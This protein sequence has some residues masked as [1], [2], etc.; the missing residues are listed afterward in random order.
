[1]AREIFFWQDKIFF[2][3]GWFGYCDGKGNYSVISRE[4][5][6][7]MVSD[8]HA[9]QASQDV[10]RGG[11]EM[12]R[13]FNGRGFELVDGKY[14]YKGN[15]VERLTDG[16]VREIG[17]ILEIPEKVGNY[18]IN[19][20]HKQAFMG[21]KQIKKVILHEKIDHIG[22]KAFADC[23][24]LWAVQG[25]SEKITVMADAFANTRLFAGECAEYLKNVLL[26]VNT[27][28]QGLFVVKSGITSIAEKAFM[29]CKEITE[30]DLPESVEYIENFAFQDCE[31]LEKIHMPKSL[32]RLGAGAFAGCKS[33]KS[34]IVP[35]GVPE[36]HRGTF[37]G[38]ESL[39]EVRLPETIVSIGHDAFQETALM[40]QFE[41]GTEEALYVD[42]W[43]IRYKEDFAETL[44]I[45]K[46][47]VGVADMPNFRKRYL[48]SVAFPEGLKYIG[49]CA[50]EKTDLKTLKLPGTLELLKRSA[51][52][53][54]KIK[55]VTLPESVKQVDEW[56]FMDCEDIE[57]I[58]V[59]GKDTQI[60][61][62]AVTDRTGGLTTVIEAPLGSHAQAYCEQ[63]GKKYNLVFEE[64][65]PVVKNNIFT[66]RRKK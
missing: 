39:L 54:T 26:K 23:E 59:E 52:R 43:L 24:N 28:N 32:L 51:F 64:R 7:K 56:V 35:E 65:K 20:I 18:P 14:V 42:N 15:D 50:F 11:A 45:K 3:D 36:I 10:E 5:A 6:C 40:K 31:N 46:G 19:R 49:Y 47:T 37:Y 44:Y 9:Y 63:Y 33:L 41:E 57:R 29:N 2:E 27:D 48:K 30:I 61:W 62:P 22:Q 4:C 66:L 34:I 13:A 21:N 55:E 12:H 53:G 17:E 38:C 60:V 16:P 58:I 25:L 1:M 8:Y